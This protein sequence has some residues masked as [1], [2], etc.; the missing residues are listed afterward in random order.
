MATVDDQPLD[1]YA[2]LSHKG[3]LNGT[4]TPDSSLA[5]TWVPKDERRRLA[6]YKVLA[7]YRSNAARRFLPKPGAAFYE[8]EGFGRHNELDGR[9]TRREYGD[10]ELIVDRIRAGVLGDQVEIVVDGADDDLPDEPDLPPRP[11]Q[12]EAEAEGS[13][14]ADGSALTQLERRVAQVRMDRWEQA[15]TDV[16]ERWLDAVEG[17]PALVERQEW[18]RDWADSEGLLAKVHEGEGD[19]VGL[20]DGVYVLAW[21][22][23]KQRPVVQV[24]DPGFYFPVLDHTGGQDADY[25]TRV[26]LAWEYKQG[27]TT[28]VRRLTFELGPIVEQT[29]VDPGTGDETFELADGDR[30][31]ADGRIVRTYPWADD[32]Q[33][34]PVESDQTCYF[35]DATWPL[36]EVKASTLS[37]LDNLSDEAPGVTYAMTDDGTV[38][39]RLDLRIDFLPVVHVPNTP[40]SREHFGASALLLVAQVLDDIAASDTDVQAASALAA[41]PMVAMSGAQASDTVEVRPGTV[42]KLPAEGRMDVLDMSAGLEQLTGVN[43]RL[44]DRLSVN[45]RVPA[46]VLGRVKVSEAP[47]GVAL[48]LGF[49]PFT[50]LVT[51]LRLVRAA[52]YR[53]LLKMVQRLAQ[54]GGVLDPGLNPDARLAFGSYLPTDR[55]AIV[56]A[57]K[58]ALAAGAISTQTAVAWLV[59]AGFTVDDAKSEVQRIR[60]EHP[61]Q[62]AQIADATASETLAAD[63]LGVTIP[64]DVAVSAPSAGPAPG[65]PDVGNGADT[66]EAAT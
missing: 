27:P 21:S 1:L 11:D 13:D 32:D 12:P 19:S 54:A 66:D 15:A 45:G 39:R 16:F 57:T 29:G 64:E 28:Y 61:A 25:P 44:L 63:W 20:G 38:A 52:K 60:Y 49:G 46:E 33:G 40:A 62:A 59:D 41:G 51:T 5:P 53:L 3:V 34:R 58:D 65:F 26:H 7:A 55:A 43:E 36:S 14:S 42:Y 18:L 2:P 4:S 24:Y 47:S 23:A 35:T 50:Q 31:D 56:T 8:R 22:E 10:A 37:G 17:Q 9:D 6:A 30:Y 48:A